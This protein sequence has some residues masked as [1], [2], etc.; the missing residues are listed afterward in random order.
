MVRSDAALS[1]NCNDFDFFDPAPESAT[2]FYEFLY[3]LGQSYGMFSYE[4]DFLNQNHN[5][6]PRFIA[7]V[8][9][10]ATVFGAQVR[11][12][13]RLGGCEFSRRR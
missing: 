11:R 12:A 5:C 6:V 8:G 7:E 10:A 2:A 4:P 3:D 9:A 1:P 13:G